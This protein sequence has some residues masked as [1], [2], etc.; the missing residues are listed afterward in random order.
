MVT[1]RESSSRF[2]GNNTSNNNSNNTVIES[3]VTGSI[4]SAVTTI[5][6]QPL[7]LLKTRI[8]IQDNQRT[9]IEPIVGRLSQSAIQLARSQGLSSL[10]K[11]TGASLL[12]SVPGVGLYYAS[13]NT[14]Q[15]NFSNQNNR[16]DSPIQAFYF[17]LAARSLVSFILLPI[18]VVKV[19]YESGRY[20]YPSLAQALKNAYIKPSN[21]WVGVTPTILRD[22]LFSGIYYMCYIKLK[23]SS[24]RA[25]NSEQQQQ[26]L[27]NFSNGIISGLIAS[28]LTNPLDVIK[29]NIQVATVNTTTDKAPM[30]QVI[31][32]L[33]SQPRGY[34]RFFDGLVPR[35]ARRTLIA[36]S[37]WSFYELMIELINDN[38][39][40]N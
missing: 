8:Q 3:L 4:S 12:R 25:D 14:L 18:T 2:R 30:R 5:V 6:Y 32:Q 29:T 24:Q 20:Q 9:K 19:R 22:S 27:R 31:A 34:L 16:P 35:S 37:T 26:H 15:S 11:G 33:L 21:G 28:I 7:E 1:P 38:K 10:W 13:L 17:G 36:A 39:Y 23:S 40:H